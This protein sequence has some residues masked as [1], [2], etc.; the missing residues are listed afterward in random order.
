MIDVVTL[1]AGLATRDGAI[2]VQNNVARLTG[3]SGTLTYTHVQ[4][5]K[6]TLWKAIEFYNLGSTADGSIRVRFGDGTNQYWLDDSDM[7]FKQVA[8]TSQWSSEYTLPWLL[9]SADLWT[10]STLQLVVHLTKDGENKDPQVSDIRVLLDNPTW[11]GAITNTLRSIAKHLSQSPFTLIHE[12]TLSAPRGSWKIGKPY[13]EHNYDV[14][15]ILQVTVDGSHKSATL[16]NG[17]VILSGPPAPAGSR[18]EIAVRVQPTMTVRRSDET[19]VTHQ[20]PCW[21]LTGLVVEGGL[22]GHTSSMLIGGEK[23]QVREQEL[24]TTV[25]GLGHR[26]ADALAMRLALQEAFADGL[27]I[28]F[29]SGRCVFA[30][31]DGLVE[32]IEGDDTSLPMATGVILVVV[33]EYVFSKTVRYQRVDGDGNPAAPGQP[34]NPIP[35]EITVAFPEDSDGFAPVFNENGYNC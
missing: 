31:V 19:R 10:R 17:E 9:G 12:E 25:N 7:T 28:T 3:D 15:S 35:T 8:D 21:W 22:I 16:S 5:T 32:V 13:S 1:K 26:Q 11:E 30:Q 4:P 34:G 6:M 29:P 20:T 24:R 2:R 18:V 14:R 27:S 23:V 33:R